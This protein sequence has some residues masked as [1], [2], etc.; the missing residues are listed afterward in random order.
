V[1]SLDPPIAT[2]ARKLKAFPKAGSYS[3]SIGLLQILSETSN[4]PQ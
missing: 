4:E 1:V 3:I 2:N